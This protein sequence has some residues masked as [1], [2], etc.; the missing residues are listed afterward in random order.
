MFGLGGV[1]V[2]VFEDTSFGIAPV[3]DVE[4]RRMVDGIDASPILHG[5][6]GRQPVDVEAVAEVVERVSALASD[7]PAVLELDINPL[8]ASTDGVSAVDLRLTVDKEEL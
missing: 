3:T 5:A 6:R 7:L 4:A 8:V 1:F 2:E